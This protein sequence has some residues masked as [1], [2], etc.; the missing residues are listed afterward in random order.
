MRLPFS[1]SDAPIPAAQA[2]ALG[3]RFGPD[4]ATGRMV[5]L[6]PDGT[7]LGVLPQSNPATVSLPKSALGQL[8]SILG[9][10]SAVFGG[11]ALGGALSGAGAAGAGAAAPGYVASEVGG[12]AA[13]I[14]GAG[15]AG[16]GAAAGGSGWLGRALTAAG[17]GLSAAMDSR[18]AGQDREQQEASERRRT[19]LEESTL[20][21]YRFQRAQASAASDL[22]RLA[23]TEYSPVHYEA[24]ARYAGYVPQ[25]TGG[26]TY[27]RSDSVRSGARQLRDDVLAGHTAPSVTNPA[28]VGR[29]PSL[30]LRDQ[31]TQQSPLSTAPAAPTLSQAVPGNG[32]LARSSDRRRQREIAQFEAANPGWTIDPSGRVVAKGA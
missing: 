1:L 26:T 11:A 6:K 21:P 28:N 25:R 30:D 10:A 14:G 17:T 16:A 8:G 32:F 13:G 29:T 5:W 2:E 31:A 18:R 22:D 20:D 3:Y 27:N 4:P 23:E 15:A 12:T 24:P 7:R 19:S 9:G